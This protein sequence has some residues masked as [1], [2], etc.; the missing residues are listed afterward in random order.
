MFRRRHTFC[1]LPR[2]V[3]GVAFALVDL[4]SLVAEGVRKTTA[5]GYTQLWK[6]LNSIV[7]AFC[8]EYIYDGRGRVKR[9][10]KFL[11]VGMA[12]HWEY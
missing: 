5:F 7:E 8:N 1:L 12:Y 9:A 10:I 11:L 2:V 4:S 3:L 6:L